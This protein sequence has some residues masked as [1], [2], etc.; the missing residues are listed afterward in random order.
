M[1]I[2][3]SAVCFLEGKPRRHCYDETSQATSLQSRQLARDD[4]VEAVYTEE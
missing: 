2:V 4:M 3:N 1:V